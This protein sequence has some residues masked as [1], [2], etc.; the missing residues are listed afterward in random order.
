MYTLT[1][2]KKKNVVRVVALL[3]VLMM[4]TTLPTAPLTVGA[5]S[6][7]SIQDE[8][9]KLQKEQEKLAS[10]KKQV[11]KNID[12]T[13]KS[14]E[15]Q[16][17]ELALTK[18]QIVNIQNQIDVYTAEINR[19]DQEIEAKNEQ[20]SQME[21]EVAE[22]TAAIEAQLNKLKGRVQAIAQTGNMSSL[23]MLMNTDE[24]AD[25]LLKSQV[26]KQISDSDQALMD[27]LE[28]QKVAINAQKDQAQADRDAVESV[29]A[30][31]AALKKDMDVQKANVDALYK[32]Q[33]QKEDALNKKLDTYQAEQKKLQDLENKADAE[34]KRLLEKLNEDQPNDGSNKYGGTMF[35]PAPTVL[36]ISSHFGYRWGS[37]HGGTDISNGRSDNEPIV[38]AADGT[39]ISVVNDHYSYGNYCM[40]DHGYD[41]QGRRIVTLY[42]HM[43]KGSPV[44]KVGQKV[45]GGQTLLGRI[46][47]TGN[48][49][50]PHLHFEVR[51]NGTRVDA[52]KNGYIAL[53]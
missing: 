11:E 46:G 12:S 30:E 28:A 14:I 47:S 38:A 51:V 13:E 43:R 18:K 9:D 5:A 1:S 37:L 19:L 27:D 21:Q 4:G 2:K 25:Y 23:Q 24:Y 32:E 50:G 16:Q 36:K 20:I 17:E 42:A 7:S 40:I 48:S 31:Q 15:Q 49:T 44:V 34:I 52:V 3:S 6:S 33:K 35:W 45:V 8:I 41:S 39:V 26:M 22:K 53:P 29:R 10:E